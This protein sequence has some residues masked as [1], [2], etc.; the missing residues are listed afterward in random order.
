MSSI[1]AVPHRGSENLA[2][3][4]KRAWASFRET[5]RAEPYGRSL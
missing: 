5:H 4:T 1:W 3:R 2:R